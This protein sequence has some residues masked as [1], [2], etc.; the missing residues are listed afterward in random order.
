MKGKD[1]M[2][3]MLINMIKRPFQLIRRE[4]LRARI[5]LER[6]TVKYVAHRGL[7]AEAPE[8]TVRA[9]ELAAERHF[10]AMETDIRRTKDH[11]LVL[12]HD[13]S[14]KRMCGVDQLVENLTYDELKAIPVTGGNHPERYMDDPKAQYVPLL[15]EYLEICRD[16][17]MIPMMELKDNWNVPEPLDDEYLSDI[18]SQVRT[19]MGESPV[20]F[21][22]F[23]LGSLVAMKRLAAE[24]N[25]ENVTL[26]HLVRKVT[27]LDLAWYLKEGIHLSLQGKANKISD[28]RKVN[29]AGLRTV[30]W[31]VDNKDQARLYIWGK[32]EW[33]ASNGQLWS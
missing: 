24:Q 1:D 12:M 32:V 17:G 26:Y 30:V 22:S 33:V 15:T 2:S 11:K 14:L 10:D 25:M 29:K 7:S 27:E 31:T 8:N 13:A 20:I 18:L 23:N 21:V 19:I 5:P 3:L 9:F 16:S 28:I 4:W 6:S